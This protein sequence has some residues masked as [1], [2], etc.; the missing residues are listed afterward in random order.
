MIWKD[1]KT[2]STDDLSNQENKHFGDTSSDSIS[3]D[4][5]QNP[6]QQKQ[7]AIYDQKRF[8]NFNCL[9]QH[10]E[11]IELRT[12]PSQS[13]KFSQSSNSINLKLYNDNSFPIIFK[14]KT[15]E[16]DIIAS[17][18]ARGFIQA[19][20]FIECRL[21]SIETD[22]RI[23]F[24]VQYTRILNQYDDYI[25]QWKNLKSENIYIKNFHCN[26]Q[27]NFQH[28]TQIDSKQKFLKPILFTF[29]TITLLT[30]FIYFRNK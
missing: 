14:L 27:F 4:T 25:T 8:D 18:P 7:S 29:A 12:K 28:E 6:A 30:A 3:L 19:N 15:T 26:F 24:V 22:Y 23:L 11:L 1:E 21:T 17:Q 2:I 20:S 16:P 10:E 5:H 13:L 9:S